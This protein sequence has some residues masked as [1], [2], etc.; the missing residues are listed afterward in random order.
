MPMARTSLQ[1]KSSAIQPTERR[2][3]SLSAAHG[4]FPKADRDSRING[5]PR[6]EQSRKAE[7]IFEQLYRL[8][9]PHQEGRH[10]QRHLRR[11]ST[12]Y[13][14]G[15]FDWRTHELLPAR[16]VGPG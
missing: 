6:E 11:P 2:G 16:L 14:A 7:K 3:K 12:G 5:K 1:A 10:R 9:R 8:R 13:R 15:Q 4:G